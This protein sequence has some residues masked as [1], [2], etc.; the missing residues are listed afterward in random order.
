MTDKSTPLNNGQWQKWINGYGIYSLNQVTFRWDAYVLKVW[1]DGLYTEG[2]GGGAAT[3][4]Y[5]TLVPR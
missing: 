2:G 3:K 1:W 5:K 4:S